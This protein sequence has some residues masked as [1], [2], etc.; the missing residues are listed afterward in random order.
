MLVLLNHVTN[1]IETKNGTDV[2][3]HPNNVHEE[4]NQQISWQKIRDLLLDNNVNSNPEVR[5][6]SFSGFITDQ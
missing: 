3:R 5:R 2:Q 6:P 4:G 1:V